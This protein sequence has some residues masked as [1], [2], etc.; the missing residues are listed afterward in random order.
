MEMIPIRDGYG[1]GL[2]LAGKENKDVVVLCA[3]L[4]DSTR[5]IVFQKEFP[6]RFIEVGIA[7]QNMAGIAAGLAVSGKIPFIST[8]AV[9]C[10]GRNWDQ[11]RVNVCYNNANVKLT[12]AHSG[13]SVGPDGATHQALEDIAITRCLPNMVVLAPC[14]AIETRKATLAAS[15][16]QGPVY[17]RFAREKTPVFTTEETPF[18]IGKAVPFFEPKNKDKVDVVIIACGPLVYNSLLSAKELEGEG[19]SIAVLNNHTI[20]PIDEEHIIKAAKKA[21]AVVTV[22]DHQIMGGM[23]SAV[24]E[25]LAKNCPTPQEFIGMPNSFGESGQP[26]ELLE[27]Y[28]MGVKDIKEA[29]RRALK[30]KS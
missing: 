24:A 7:E 6:E 20:K 5:S 4:T 1:Q 21:G 9:F 25:V 14:D 17:L 27:K 26:E 10:P 16:I 28:G 2:I 22:E 15:K 23:G 19:L 29:V 12:G 11:I 30:R 13:V 8:Y 18:E 3:D